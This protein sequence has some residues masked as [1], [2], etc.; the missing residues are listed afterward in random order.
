MGAVTVVR[1][2][3]DAGAGVREER[4][5]AVLRSTA[6]R[7]VLG[8][9]GEARPRSFTRQGRQVVRARSE[10]PWTI[11]AEDLER[12]DVEEARRDAWSANAAVV[13]RSLSILLIAAL[14]SRVPAAYHDALIQAMQAMVNLWTRTGGDT[15]IVPSLS[16]VAEKTSRLAATRSPEWW[17]Q[18]FLAVDEQASR[19]RPKGV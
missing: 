16:E 9:R 14:D 12:I 1:V 6:S 4:G 7:V 18:L 3:R 5:A 11:R 10:T 17:E 19:R 2:V 8:V 15:S 13:R